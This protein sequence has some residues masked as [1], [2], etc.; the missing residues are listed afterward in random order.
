MGQ[1]GNR[2]DGFDLRDDLTPSV[3]RWREN[4]AQIYSKV[5]KYPEIS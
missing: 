3:V 4:N 5:K 1:G 2:P